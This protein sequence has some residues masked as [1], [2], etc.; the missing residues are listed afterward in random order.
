[1]EEVQELH[2]LSDSLHSLSLIN[3]NILWQNSR[4]LWLKEWDVKSKF[5][6]GIMSSRRRANTVVTFSVNGSTV[7]GVDGIRGAVYNHFATHF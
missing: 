3:T 5:F 7:E 2:S 4:L 1:M 6:H